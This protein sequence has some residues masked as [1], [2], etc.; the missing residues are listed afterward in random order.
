MV[1]STS[2]TRLLPAPTPVYSFFARL[3]GVLERNQE[4][5]RIRDELSQMNSRELADLGLTHSDIDDVAAGT[6][7]RD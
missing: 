3:V 1:N 7:R 5:A 6:Y 4:Q 2:T